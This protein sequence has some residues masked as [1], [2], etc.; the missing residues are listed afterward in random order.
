MFCHVRLMG[1]N[2]L[3]NQLCTVPHGSERHC[4]LIS[5]VPTSYPSITAAFLHCRC[6]SSTATTIMDRRIVALPL[7]FLYRN[8]DNECRIV[9]RAIVLATADMP[10]IVYMVINHTNTTKQCDLKVRGSE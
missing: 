4:K 5:D 8:H 7:Y 10:A 9:H 2:V 6:I 1:F 3:M